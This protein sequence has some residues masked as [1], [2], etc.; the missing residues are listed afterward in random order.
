MEE[1]RESGEI[2]DLI[3]EMSEGNPGAVRVMADLIAFHGESTG[4]ELLYKLKDNGYTGEKIWVLFKDKFGMSIPAL[5]H[6]INGQ[7]KRIEPTKKAMHEEEDESPAVSPSQIPESEM[8][9]ETETI[10][11]P[12]AEGGGG[13]FSGGGASGDFGGGDSGGGDSSSGSDSGSASS[14]DSGGGVGGD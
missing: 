5:G 8:S 9:S 1:Q 7:F 13:E 2:Q 4:L 14:G 3:V 11:T 12:D 6:Y 10:S